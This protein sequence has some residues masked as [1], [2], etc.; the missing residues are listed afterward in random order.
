MPEFNPGKSYQKNTLCPGPAVILRV[1]ES[2]INNIKSVADVTSLWFSQ[3][4][5]RNQTNSGAMRNSSLTLHTELPISCK[6]IRC[7]SKWINTVTASNNRNSQQGPAHAAPQ[8]KTPSDHGESWLL[9]RTEGRWHIW[10]PA[11]RTGSCCG[12]PFEDQGFLTSENIKTW[13]TM[14]PNKELSTRSSQ[15]QTALCLSWLLRVLRVP[16]TPA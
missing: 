1:I 8:N 14:V 13:Y 7:F 2:L 16:N 10:H 4:L 12:T 11:P 15:N 6:V 9:P 3:V 5:T